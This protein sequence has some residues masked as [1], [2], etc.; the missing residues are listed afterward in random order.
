MTSDADSFW[1]EIA[2][3]Y[4]KLKGYCP[5]TPE[6]ADAAYD[7]APEIPMSPEEI[8]RIVDAVVTGERPEF[9]P[10]VREWSPEAELADVEEDMLA[11]FREEGEADPETDAKEEELR[12]RMLND[13]TTDEQ[14]GLDGGAASP[15]DGGEDG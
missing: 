5:M 1:N 12:K 10:E 13:E 4:R 14:D 7:A 6:E 3:K 11:V 8:E 15:G 2:P 9:D